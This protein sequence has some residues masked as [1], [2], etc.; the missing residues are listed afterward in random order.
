MGLVVLVFF[1]FSSRRRHTRC[2]LVTGVQ[3][4]ALPISC[5]VFTCVARPRV[6]TL[7]SAFLRRPGPW[8]AL[9]QAEFAQDVGTMFA[10]SRREADRK[11]LAVEFH[12]YA[13]KEDLA[14]GGVEP[15]REE[16]HGATGN[17][18][19]TGREREGR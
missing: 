10:Q 11:A 5:S 3:T 9:R 4:C 18:K 15:G 16:I 6:L 7:G 14:D 2:A 1:F 12:R 17:G 8:R 19:E 13:G